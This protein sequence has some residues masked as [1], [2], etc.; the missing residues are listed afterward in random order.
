M[1]LKS[2]ENPSWKEFYSR[3]TCLDPPPWL[4]GLHFFFPF[5]INF[6]H[7]FFF[8]PSELKEQ[9]P[10]LPSEASSQSH[11]AESPGNEVYPIGIPGAAF[12]PPGDNCESHALNLLADLALGSCIPPFIPKDCGVIPAPRGIPGDSVEQQSLSKPKSPRVAS[13]HK[14]HR[15]EKHGRKATSAS[16]VSPSRPLPEKTHPDHPAS[17][18]KDKTCGIF[19]G[20]GGNPVPATFQVPPPREA[21]EAAEASKHSIIS[22]EHSYASPLPEHPRKH[23]NP[24]GNPGAAPAPSKN[25]ARNALAAPLVGK[26]LPFRHQQQSGAAEPGGSRSSAR[27]KE[28]F[29]KSHAVSVCGNSVKVTCRWE[30]EY[31]FHLDSRYTNDS[32]EKTVIRALH[33]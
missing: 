27:K 11:G 29:S 16:R 33:G 19:S 22:A 24:K 4:C 3:R 30:E 5:L 10:H 23:P 12:A 8:P 32:L 15:A 1:V 28:D 2:V 14:Y 26:V 6:S 31:L 25:G 9:L 21:A 18:P 20:T 13:D 17:L 7:C